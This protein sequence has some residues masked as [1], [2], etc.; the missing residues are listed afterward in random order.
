LFFKNKDLQET[1]L[2]SGGEVNVTTFLTGMIMLWSGAVVDIPDGWLLCNGNLSTPDLRGKFVVG[3]GGSYTPADTGGEA[4]HTLTI[5]ELAAHTHTQ[6]DMTK[7]ARDGTG[8]QDI[9]RSGAD[10]T[11]SST[12]G[13]AAHENRPPYYALCYIMKS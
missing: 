9:W 12:G 13:G 4:T 10:K 1:Q 6:S 2:T 5:A 3:A 7:N 8:T 11:S